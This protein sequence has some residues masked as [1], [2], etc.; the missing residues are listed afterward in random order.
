MSE[1]VQIGAQP[2]KPGTSPGSRF[3]L[4]PVCGCKSVTV[5]RMLIEL[6][7]SA[8]SAWTA[9][10]AAIRGHSR[11]NRQQ[12]RVASSIQRQRRHLVARDDLAEVGSNG[13]NLHAVE[14]VTVTVSDRTPTER[15]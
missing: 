9:P 13:V 15:T 3:C 6:G 8:Y 2:S 5:G 4:R 1:L 10:S 11:L 12:I 14:V 7:V